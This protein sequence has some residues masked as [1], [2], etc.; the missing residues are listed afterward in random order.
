MESH[1]NVH[2]EYVEGCFACHVRSISFSPSAQ[3]S[4]RAQAAVRTDKEWDRDHA[5]YRRMVKNGLQPPTLDGCAE[6]ETR[7]STQEEIERGHIYT[8]KKQMHEVEGAFRAAEEL[9]A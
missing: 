8:S 3:G 4:E 2:A 5:A 6:L 9:N 7:A 1:K